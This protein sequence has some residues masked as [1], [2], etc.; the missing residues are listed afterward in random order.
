MFSAYDC[1]APSPRPRANPL[2]AGIAQH[3]LQT[4]DASA[5][6]HRTGYWRSRTR[7]ASALGAL[8]AAADAGAYSTFLKYWLVTAWPVTR[9]RTVSP[10]LRYDSVKERM[11]DSGMSSV[12]GL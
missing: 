8:R 9:V 3:A 6:R 1:C 7:Y 10:A 11:D 2:C 4:Q 12:W 5:H